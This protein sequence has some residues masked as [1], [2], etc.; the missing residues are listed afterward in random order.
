VI[1]NRRARLVSGRQLDHEIVA[2]GRDVLCKQVTE[3]AACHAKVTGKIGACQEGE[4]KHSRSTSDRQRRAHNRKAKN[5]P[6]LQVDLN[7]KPLL[8]RIGV[9]AYFQQGI[10]DDSNNHCHDR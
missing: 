8:L 3:Y 7:M 5:S 9:L 1:L 6:A 2:T 4:L 10:D